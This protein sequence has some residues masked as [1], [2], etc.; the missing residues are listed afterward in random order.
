MKRLLISLLL[1][2]LPALASSS[3]HW[4][5][6]IS[7]GGSVI[8]LEDDSVWAVSSLDTVDT[9]IW[10]SA[11]NVV[12]AKNNSDPNYPYVMINTDEKGEVAHVKYMGTR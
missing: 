2:S 10:L 7:D 12:I 6:E 4:I 5:D 9:S 3:K 8:I 11:D 1:C